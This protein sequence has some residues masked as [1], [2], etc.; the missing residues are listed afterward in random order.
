MSLKDKEKWNQ[1]YKGPEFLTGKEPCEWL[2]ANADLLTGRGTA[3]DIAMGEGRNAVFAAQQGYRVLGLDISE[4]GV[5]KARKLA[6]ENGVR[7]QTAVVD[8][9]NY[10]FQPQAYDLILCFNFLDRRLFPGMRGALKPGGL[11]VY[12]TFNLDY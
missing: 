3:L 7:I 1:K 6:E 11:I 4:A 10:L 9:D 5:Q 12:E 2:S 8:L